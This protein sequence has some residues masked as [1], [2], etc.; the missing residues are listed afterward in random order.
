MR[1]VVIILGLAGSGKSTVSHA[2][3]KYG[4]QYTGADILYE[5][6][7][8]YNKNVDWYDDI[9]YV[10][11]VYKNL[12]IMIKRLLKK[13][14]VVVEVTGA[15]DSWKMVSRELDK[16]PKIKVIRFYIK[17][18]IHIAREHVRKRNKKM[19]IPHPLGLVNFFSKHIRINKP[20]ID[21]IIDGK[22]NPKKM[23][24]QILKIMEQN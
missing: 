6:V 12:L 16:I 7:K 23:I 22:Q 9:K 1:K 4:Y 20:K 5:K 11:A 19:S 24:S 13:G 8:R 10:N 14:N 17:V 18:P 2:L 3:V 21:F 15:A